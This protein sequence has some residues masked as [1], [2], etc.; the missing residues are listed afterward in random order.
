MP[1]KPAVRSNTFSWLKTKFD[2]TQLVQFLGLS[3]PPCFRVSFW[4][5]PRENGR[6]RLHEGDVVT[7]GYVEIAYEEEDETNSSSESSG[8]SGTDGDEDGAEDRNIPSSASGVN[9][10]AGPPPPAPIRQA[11]RSAS[12]SRSPFGASDSLHSRGL[13]CTCSSMPAKLSITRSKICAHPYSVMP[14]CSLG[15]MQ[16][17]AWD[18]DL[19]F[20]LAPVPAVCKVNQYKTWQEPEATDALSSE[21]LA[22]LRAISLQLGHPW[23][24]LTDGSLPGA[25][26]AE[27]LLAQDLH[28]A[29]Q[30][31]TVVCR[32]F[33]PDFI[34]ERVEVQLDLPATLQE[35][36]QVLHEGRDPQAVVRFP[37]LCPVEPQTV[38][39][40]ALFVALPEWGPFLVVAVFNTAVI[41]SR[42]FAAYLPPYATADFLLRAAELPFAAG[43]SVFVGD[44]PEPLPDGVEAHLFPGVLILIR[45]EGSEPGPQPKLPTL[46]GS[47]LHWTQ[48]EPLPHPD[49]ARAYCLAQEHTHCLFVTDFDSSPNFRRYLAEAIG[50][51]EDNCR[52]FSAT[53]TV[54]DCS[55]AG[56]HCCSALAACQ[57]HCADLVDGL[58][59]VL[60]DK[61][62]VA[63]GFRMAFI[64]TSSRAYEVLRSRLQAETPLGW[65]VF[66]AP[67][68]DQVDDAPLQE[69]QV[70]AVGYRRFLGTA[71]NVPFGTSTDNQSTAANAPRHPTTQAASVEDPSDRQS[72]DLE[73]RPASAEP[74]GSFG[75]ETA[76]DNADLIFL[77]LAPD[78]RPES[79]VI[80]LDFPS[81]VP[82]AIASV[83]AVRSE[84]R[85]MW[86]PVV[87][88]VMPQ[89]DL[90]YLYLLAKPSWPAFG[91][92]VAFDTR[93]IDGRLFCNNVPMLA[94]RQSLLAAAGQ[95]GK[96]FLQVFVRDMP[97][98][99]PEDQGVDLQE[100]DLISICFPDDR[101][102]ILSSPSDRLLDRGGWVIDIPGPVRSEDSLWVLGDEYNGFFRGDQFRYRRLRSDIAA[103]LG[104]AASTLSIVPAQPPLR[105]YAFRG[106]LSRSVLVA[107]Q[108]RRFGRS[109]DPED[110]V[111]FLDQRPILLG[112]T[113]GI[114]PG[115]ILDVAAIRERHAHR[116]PGYCTVHISGGQPLAPPQSHL[117]AIHDGE[118]LTVAF[119]SLVFPAPDLPPEIDPYDDDDQADSD[120]D[121]H[122]SSND[123]LGYEA[124]DRASAQR[125]AGTGSSS[126]PPA[127]RTS[128]N[129]STEYACSTACDPEPRDVRVF[130]GQGCSRVEMWS[131]PFLRHAFLEGQAGITPFLLHLAVLIMVPFSSTGI[132]RLALRTALRQHRILFLALLLVAHMQR[133]VAAP[134]DSWHSVDQVHTS[135]STCLLHANCSLDLGRPIRP[136]PTPCRSTC[137]AHTFPDGPE[138][139]HGRESTVDL[140]SLST[141]LEGCVQQ[142]DSQAF[143]LAAT[144]LE[145]LLEHFA[146]SEQTDVAH[147]LDGISSDIPQEGAQHALGK[148]HLSLSSCIP[149]VVCPPLLHTGGIPCTRLPYLQALSLFPAQQPAHFGHT[150]LGFTWRELSDFL[151]LTPHFD[152][153]EEV[154]GEA[155]C[156]A[157]ATPPL[158]NDALRQLAGDTP[159]GHLC[160]FTDGSFFPPRDGI[161]AQTGWAALFVD[162]HEGLFS[163]SSGEIFA[164]LLGPHDTLSA[165]Q[166]ECCALAMAATSAVLAFSGREIHFYSDCVAALGA[167]QGTCGFAVGG[168]PEAMAAAFDLRHRG[169]GGADS[170]SYIPGH[171][172]AFFNEAAD[173]LAKSSAK[174]ATAINTTQQSM[175]VLRDWLGKGGARLGWATLIIRQLRGAPELPPIGAL[176]LGTDDWHAGLHHWHLLQPFLPT[177]VWDNP[178]AQQTT[179]LQPV[180]LKLRLLSYNTLSLGG[181]LEDS[182]GAVEDTTGLCRRPGRAALLARQLEDLDVTLASLQETRCPAGTTQVGAYLRFSSGALKGQWGT[183][184]WIRKGA[185]L[186]EF[187]ATE[188]QY[189]QIERKNATVVYSDPRRMLPA[190]RCHS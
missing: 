61:R 114:A 140:S 11:S 93:A 168:I 125:D 55:V 48:V 185:A 151:S 96:P 106:Q 23:P 73:G 27:D 69:G 14:V 26:L 133:A 159:R 88:P 80:T 181:C 66:L 152:T 190:P 97:W 4:P 52:H 92:F 54:T 13:S 43:F 187:P 75:L 45:H 21:R 63:D 10:P 104:L 154:F 30:I 153:W 149:C 183:E 6:L 24:G 113:W 163:I 72:G 70:F 143:F 160:C 142:P 138:Q 71:D 177:G 34:P 111:Y 49:I 81:T 162:P 9:R 47:P 122:S 87:I 57:T 40:Q 145:T 68:G 74:H 78:Y 173:M 139:D 146:F 85:W 100:G 166:A 184:I 8:D 178:E 170:F 2:P 62:A 130:Q 148:T 118:T 172:G 53:P 25:L 134:V 180:R 156:I 109:S 79:G 77:L 56:V 95:H 38:R 179:R 15:C 119:V 50:A 136:I 59:T 41:D 19:A 110:A 98:P 116:C 182:Q 189:F 51:T 123:S 147:V 3:A 31:T 29:P 135:D 103:L 91:V 107:T 82:L 171:Q 101:V 117:H 99:L 37:H 186:F 39:G 137:L 60:L 132:I 161:A 141:L 90:D 46:L 128:G 86:F 176:H 94:T 188:R 28:L 164:D 126:F 22:D 32:V 158:L 121:G 108:E 169:C 44:D 165:Y 33:V 115:G 124:G 65:E 131:C 1:D 36:E 150:D 5:R 129:P 7:F 174:P 157:K 64:A 20:L 84:Q 67:S 12:R 102:A 58:S 127:P 76:T 144:L 35:L 167:A 18:L 42:V 83:N 105:D 175:V 120:T 16:L 89:P 112:V 155:V 17:C